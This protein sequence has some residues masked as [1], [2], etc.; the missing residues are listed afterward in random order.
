MRKL[1]QYLTVGA[2]L[3]ASM[4]QGDGANAQDTLHRVVTDTVWQTT[5]T[6]WH[7]DTARFG[8]VSIIQNTP[9]CDSCGNV[10][11]VIGRKKSKKKKIKNVDL[12]WLNFDFGFNNYS[13]RSDY[14]SPEVNDFAPANPGDPEATSSVFSLRG[15]K[16][17]NVNI[18]PVIANVNIVQHKLNLITGIGIVM[19]NYR[20]SKDI[21]YVNA[22]SKTYVMRDSVSFKKN[23]L[24]TEYLTIPLLLNFE[25]NPY[26]TS[27]SF[28]I[29][30][31]PTFGYLVKS[32]TK[33]V[34]KARGKIKD[35]DAF[36]LET[37]RLGL[38]GEIGFGPV[39]LYGS[40]SLTPIHQYGLKQYP[41]SIGIELISH[42]SS[43]P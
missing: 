20:Y 31:G 37:F 30:A 22:F 16:S 17:V 9:G 5:D 6:T 8:P 34:S 11:V 42:A 43:I 28:R 15:G 7:P 40:Y 23:K 10:S 18:W 24:F 12:S 2:V 33:Q 3:S 41:F 39:T 21:S 36:N 27:N 1:I 25:S 4:L 14:G 19:N 35:N 32:R 26:H 13:D 29:S 38:R